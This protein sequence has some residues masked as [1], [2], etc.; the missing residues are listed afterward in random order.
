MR[1]SAPPGAAATALVDAQGAILQLSTGADEM[2]AE[3]GFLDPAARA[4]TPPANGVAFLRAVANCARLA[5]GS[6]E[7]APPAPMEWNT[8]AGAWRVHAAPYVAGDLIWLRR[9]AA[10]A[11]V[12]LTPRALETETDALTALFGLTAAER[13]LAMALVRGASLRDFAAM[14]GVSINTARSQLAQ[15]RIKTGVRTQAQIVRRILRN[16]GLDRAFHPFG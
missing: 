15:L 7:A 10:P 3:A 11:F 14:R 1:A 16:A 8:P 5:E 9:P 6:I 2:L 13:S 4:I 12:P